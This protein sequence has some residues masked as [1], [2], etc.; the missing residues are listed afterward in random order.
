MPMQKAVTCIG[1]QP[2]S[3]TYVFGPKLHF[4]ENGNKIID[5]EQEFIWIPE[6]LEKLQCPINCLETLPEL[7]D[8]NPLHFVI[9]G[10]QKILGENL[11]SG[12]SML[13]KFFF[14]QRDGVKEVYIILTTC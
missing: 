1:L 4:N 2:D 3:R 12:M 11:A 7:E 13:G 6:I 8:S 14:H 5:A 9:S 10:L